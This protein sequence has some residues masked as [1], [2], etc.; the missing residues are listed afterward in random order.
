MS[1]CGGKRA[2][3]RSLAVSAS[4]VQVADRRNRS[5]ARRQHGSGAANHEADGRRQSAGEG[6]LGYSYAED[7][8]VPG[9]IHVKE[10]W[11]IRTRWIVTL[12]RRISPNGEPLG[13][14]LVSE[15]VTFASMIS[16]NR[17]EH[18][19]G[20]LYGGSGMADYGIDSGDA[21]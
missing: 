13:R 10:T 8:F 7:V 9:L 21:E 4:L 15:I 14:A 16:E 18:S 12:R 1:R 20:L 11:S 3:F 5:L 2:I 19:S 6:C 17:V